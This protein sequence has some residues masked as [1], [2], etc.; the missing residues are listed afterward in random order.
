MRVCYLRYIFVIGYWR[1]SYGGGFDCI[2]D[3]FNVIVELYFDIVIVY[4]VYFNFNVCGLV[5]V[6]FFCLR[7]IYFIDF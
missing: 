5:Y 2:C 1:E 3:V 7:N 6:K 4:F